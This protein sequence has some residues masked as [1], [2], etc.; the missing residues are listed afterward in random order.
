MSA[1]STR[2]S[3]FSEKKAQRDDAVADTSNVN[4]TQK[5]KV[6][7]RWTD[8]PR[9]EMPAAQQKRRRSDVAGNPNSDAA[10]QVPPSSGGLRLADFDERFDAPSFP[11]QT[12][13]ML[14]KAPATGE[15]NF[16]TGP[17]S[18]ASQRQYRLKIVQQPALGSAFGE[19]LLSR[20]AVAPPLIL[21]L[22]AVDG[23]GN[24]VDISGEV[25]FLVCQCALTLENGT[26]ADLFSPSPASSEQVSPTPSP[27]RS[28]SALG[29]SMSRAPSSTGS[30][31]AGPTAAAR[32]APPSP[33]R[34]SIG[35][36]RGRR[37][38]GRGTVQGPTS[39]STAS[40]A[41]PLR[42]LVPPAR[43]L[44]G[45]LAANP[46]P[47]ESPEG[48][49]KLYLLFPEISIRATGRFRL[50]C[51]LVSVPIS[52]SSSASPGALAQVSTE[53]FDVVSSSDY[54]APYITDLTRHF[55]RQ[56]A[57]LLLPPGQAAD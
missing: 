25:P 19:D 2:S 4:P 28:A 48:G 17:Q 51:F 43:M 14:E 34:G 18:A 42:E 20:L 50:R 45:T 46:I 3:R 54:V 26:S 44:Y 55:A 11:V 56:G 6:G 40:P 37:R 16:S 52:G 27:S 21:E 47:Y 9:A 39:S 31:E 38:S 8:A 24:Q 32:L 7:D 36:R 29:P 49:E 10:E 41:S 15:G 22:D 53:P 5:G 1:S 23:D 33:S 35:R 12:S 57:G 13:R 30:V